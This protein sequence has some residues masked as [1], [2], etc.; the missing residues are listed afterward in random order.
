MGVGFVQLITTGNEYSIFNDNPQITFFKAYYRRFSNFFINNSIVNGN[1]IKNNSL[2]YVI[3][4]NG[5]LLSKTYLNFEFDESC[6]E[7]FNEYANLYTTLTTDITSFYDAYSIRI[8]LFDKYDINKLNIVKIN[9]YSNE[10][11]YLTIMSTNII[12]SDIFLSII[13][14]DMS[15]ILEKDSLNF[16]YNANPVYSFYSFNTNQDY[17]LILKYFLTGFDINSIFYLR[18]DVQNFNISFKIKNNNLV[19]LYQQILYLLISNILVKNQTKIKFNSD[20]IYLFINT[21]ASS[22]ADLFYD[23]L[24]SLIT[25]NITVANIE[26]INNKIKSYNISVN[27]NIGSYL[28]NIL[29]KSSTNYYIY[30]DM[31]VTDSV[32]NAKLFLL[33]DS[34]FFG[35]ISND[36]FNEKLIEN[37]TKLIQN[38]NVNSNNLSSNLYIRTLISIVCID[39][40]SIQSYLSIIS[41]TFNKSCSR[42]SLLNILYKYN[43]SINIFNNKILD[44]IIDPNVLIL[45]K[46]FFKKIL[47]QSVI[48]SQYNTENKITPFVNKQI[49][50]FQGIILNYY[51]YY[52]VIN[53][54]SSKY[55]Q[56][57]NNFDLILGN[58]LLFCNITTHNVVENNNSLFINYY[59]NYINNNNLYSMV[60]FQSSSNSSANLLDNL[61]Q[62]NFTSKIIELLVF[63][64]LVVFIVESITVINNIYDKLSNN[65][66]S[67]NGKQSNLFFNKNNGKCIFPLSSN[68]F[69]YTKS[70]VE[71]NSIYQ[72]TIIFNKSEHDYLSDI[73]INVNLAISEDEKLYKTTF[74]NKI[75]INQEQ[76]FGSGII[77]STILDYIISYYDN[78]N[79]NENSYNGNIIIDFLNQIN[80]INNN[81]LYALPSNFNLNDFVLKNIFIYTDQNLFNNTFSRYTWGSNLSM[82]TEKN[83]LKFIF[84]ANTPIYKIYYLYTWLAYKSS[85][86][87]PADI[88]ILRDLVLGFI[89]QYIKFFNP[90]AYTNYFTNIN[91]PSFNY[92]ELFNS[93]YILSNNF[94]SFDSIDSINTDIFANLSSTNTNNDYLY[95]YVSF[96]FI[97]NFYLIDSNEEDINFKNNITNFIN[98]YKYNYDDVMITLLLSILKTNSKVFLN[99][100][101][102][103]SFVKCFFNKY[104]FNFELITQLYKNIYVKNKALYT[105][106]DEFNTDIFYY[107]CYYSTYSIGTLF[108][109]TNLLII[110]TINN[111]FNVTTIFNNYEK[112]IN[113]YNFK[114]F[115]IKQYQNYLVNNNIIEGL[116]HFIDLYNEIIFISGII[117]Y[118]LYK[119]IIGGMYKYI[120]NNFTYLDKY[121]LSEYTFRDANNIINEYLLIFNTTNDTNITLINTSEN[122]FESEQYTKFNYCVIMLNYLM[123]VSQCLI[124]DVNTFD[125]LNNRTINFSQ[126]LIN[127]YSINIYVICL[128]DLISIFDVEENLITLDYSAILIRN[129]TNL[130]N[131]YVQNLLLM[132]SNINNQLQLTNLL[133]PYSSINSDQIFLINYWISFYSI[134]RD[135]INNYVSQYNKVLYSSISNSLINKDIS[136]NFLSTLSL[137][138]EFNNMTNIIYNN[139]IYLIKQIIYP[140]LLNSYSLFTLSNQNYFNQYSTR[141]ANVLMDI[142]KNY[143]NDVN[144]NYYNTFYNKICSKIN[145]KQQLINNDQINETTTNIVNYTSNYVNTLISNTLFYE[146]EFN[147]VI[148]ILCTTHAINLSSSKIKA[149][150]YTKLNS[151]YSIVKIYSPLN[152]TY[153]SNTSLYQDKDIF[154]LFNYENQMDNNSFIQNKFI[155]KMLI[156]IEE[157]P[158]LNNSYFYYFIAFKNYCLK[159]Y[160][161]IINF[162]LD[163]N[164]TLVDYFTSIDNVYILHEYVYKYINLNENFSPIHIYNSIIEVKNQNNVQLLMTINLDN[165]KKKII[166]YLYW[167]YLILI[168]VSKFLIID[169]EYIENDYILEYD[170][171]FE[172]VKFNLKT[173]LNKSKNK[174]FENFIIDVFS[175]D[176]FLDIDITQIQNIDDLDK[177]EYIKYQTTNQCQIHNNFNTLIKKYISSFDLILGLVPIINNSNILLAP[178]FIATLVNIT[179]K[180]NVVFNNDIAIENTNKYNL[181]VFA[182]QLLDVKVTNMIED[183]HDISANNQLLKSNFITNCELSFGKT[184]VSNINM[185]FNLICKLLSYYGI[186][187]ANIDEDINNIIGNL[188]IGSNYINDTLE[189]YKG[190]SS[191]YQISI[192]LVENNNLNSEELSNINIFNNTFSRSTNIKYLS[193]L[194]TK[195]NNFSVLTPNDYDVT[196]S[197][198]NFANIYQNIYTK[199]YQYDYNYYNF[200]NN[201]IVIYEKLLQYYTLIINN[202]NA[203]NNLKFT[204]IYYPLFNSIF[205]TYIASIFYTT[206]N[207]DSLNYISIFNSIVNLY[208]K[209]NFKFRIN[210]NISNYKNLLIQNNFKNISN[211][212][213]TLPNIMNYCVQMY[214]YEIY[215]DD[216]YNTNITNS[217]NDTL[218]FFTQISIFENYNQIYRNFYLNYIT[219]YYISI[220]SL[221]ESINIQLSIC[222]IYDDNLLKIILN[223]YLDVIC[224][225][226]YIKIFINTNYNNNSVFINNTSNYYRSIINIINYDD[227]VSLLS[228]SF[229]ELLYYDN[230]NS[231]ETNLQNVWNKYWSNRK[232]PYI[233]YASD[234]Y[235]IIEMQLTFDQFEVLL[236]NYLFYFMYDVDNST[237]I[238]DLLTVYLMNIFNQK[239]PLMSSIINILSNKYN[240]S[241]NYNKFN[242]NNEE[243]TIKNILLKI[244]YLILNQNWGIIIYNNIDNK[245]NNMLDACVSLNNHYQLYIQ[246]PKIN[247]KKFLE[248]DGRL[249]LL[250]KIISRLIVI[251]YISYIQYQTICDNILKNCHKFVIKGELITGLNILDNP[252]IYFDFLNSNIISNNLVN[253]YYK[254]IQ[255]LTINKIIKYKVNDFKEPNSNMDNFSITLYNSLVS[256]YKL[257]TENELGVNIFNNTI[258]NILSN[259]SNSNANIYSNNKTYILNVYSVIMN[260]ISENLTIFKNI[261]GGNNLT[262][263]IN[264][265][266]ENIIQLFNQFP[267]SELDQHN[268][269]IFTLIYNEFN[270]IVNND[271]IIILFYNMCMITYFMIGGNKYNLIFQKIIMKFVNLINTN[272]IKYINY[273]Q[274]NYDKNTNDIIYLE[275]FFN[276]LNSILFTTSFNTVYIEKCVN[277][278]DGLI[279]SDEILKSTSI[280]EKAIKFNIK[281]YNGLSQTQFGLSK[282]LNKYYD[283]LSFNYLITNNKTQIW[284]EM[285][286]IVVDYNMSDITKAFKSINS[287]IVLNNIQ[288]DYILHINKLTNGLVNKFGIIKMLDNVQ[289]T[290]DSELIDNYNNQMY[291]IFIELFTNVNKL[292]SINQMLGLNFDGNNEDYIIN[293]IAPYIKIF[294]KRQNSLPI[295]FFFKDNP[296]AIPLIAAMYTEIKLKFNFFGHNICKSSYIVN[297]IIP[298]NIETSL[299]M[300]YILV[301]RDERQSICSKQIDNL[302]EKHGY[303][304]QN[305]IIDK[306]LLINNSIT[307]I[308]SGNIIVKFN[309]N[310]ENIIKELFWTLD[311]YIG[312]YKLNRNHTSKSNNS[313]LNIYD[314][315][316][317]TKFYIDGMRRDGITILKQ[318]NLNDITLNV[319]QYKYNTRANANG[320]F[321]VYSFA[322]EPEQFQPSGAFNMSTI[323]TFTIE[324]LI[325]K[326][327]LVSYFNNFNILYNINDLSIIMN[328]STLEYNFIRYQSGLS[329]LLFI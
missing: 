264:L 277:F 172:I 220:I 188:R 76:I 62:N 321:N 247:Y 81:N 106:Y 43:Q 293:G 154:Q 282:L 129:R 302:I 307:N 300:D 63:N 121:L 33:K 182:I 311:F 70:E 179:N 98:T 126:W 109:N 315:I 122:G 242:G 262:S 309:F 175:Y 127:K 114:S 189:I 155:N 320:Y 263:G 108:D 99:F 272:I 75:A 36:D 266:T 64:Y 279:N 299:S 140:N 2:T 15:I 34:S 46:N 324:L 241:T 181:T 133:N 215:S 74:N 152:K 177:I 80:V 316:L 322:L 4:K 104:T 301:E 150:A 142:I 318:K 95:M 56:S 6:V 135:Q 253:N 82:I 165:I 22:D 283:N 180:I 88:K 202:D 317:N 285:L 276:G 103:N 19:N 115:N 27:E 12:N 7:L 54:F 164:V 51:L 288:N 120:T 87:E 72:S 329:G 305:Q 96:Y 176:K 239:Q 79:R 94:L 73:F 137:K 131:N 194:V 118:R 107:N 77:K 205:N 125:N 248:M 38:I 193:Q 3:P 273:I 187:Y 271:I 18:I 294:K 190:N 314:F 44:I 246:N 171:G 78:M 178:K 228:I 221:I 156:D 280:I 49:S 153:K 116:N 47:Y 151:L 232:F 157:N 245:V 252:S 267:N 97:K 226:F 92:D 30:Y 174:L 42:D 197:N 65:I 259:Y 295:N 296:N 186:Q 167:N 123:F 251:L 105:H 312:N 13:K 23:S 268:I 261:L 183:L 89:I 169:L 233:E 55:N 265:T 29:K 138:T 284:K 136:V 211:K 146:K 203:I 214:Y 25:N 10:S 278:F 110:K 85:N 128:D 58:M 124:I 17:N 130:T 212:L 141:I 254:D 66:Y 149:I 113:S 281:T 298:E 145:I 270:S 227:F 238:I 287:I 168:Y 204:D 185:L 201:A 216:I 14:A 237:T 166:I 207:Q 326:N 257:K 217:S 292:G 144:D 111:I 132:E 286:G 45:S 170:F 303:Y 213:N 59:Q 199:F 102:I 48:N 11:K 83:Y 191:N 26:V 200:K 275:N 231:Y 24:I 289:L 173:V 260:Q 210:D 291:K 5:D 101:V 119:N 8:E 160:P 68:I 297:N 57:Y 224:K 159:Y 218:I 196:I 91:F 100:D 71:L 304:T 222:L 323:N 163:N 206:T 60:D 28:K 31:F 240:F 162:K 313:S 230:K 256:I 192:D 310:I 84:V 143:Q 243:T 244:N 134:Y 235:I 209:Y 9:L 229:N 67:S 250:Y 327:K 255:N 41:N 225:P 20:N 290:F 147:R 198:I 219:K 319:N 112:N 1:K 274:S 195:F 50:T 223:K 249:I 32:L 40:I 90:T 69:I 208:V 52:N 308:I 325:D 158:L 16:Y 86:D 93:R 21:Q 258:I 161:E 184:D 306:S 39:N 61:T 148:Y 117:S 269:T 236:T 53:C 37:E 328:L 139:S 234:D 35:N